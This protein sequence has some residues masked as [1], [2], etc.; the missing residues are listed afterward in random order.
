[1][2]GDGAGRAGVAVAS[3]SRNSMAMLLGPG[4]PSARYRRPD[5]RAVLTNCKETGE[6]ERAD[7][8]TSPLPNARIVAGT[9]GRTA[10]KPGAKS[11][12]SNRPS[13][14]VVTLARVPL[15]V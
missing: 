8:T 15:A 11:R 14:S 5:T 4:E 9:A 6:H 1:M 7:T 10:Y 13:W 12:N 2:R 3:T